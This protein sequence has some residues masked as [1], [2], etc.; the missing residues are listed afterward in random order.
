MTTYRMAM[1]AGNGGQNLWPL[2]FSLGVAA[3]TYDPLSRTNLSDY[4]PG[5]PIELWAELAPTQKASLRRVAYEMKKSDV[6]FVKQGPK[7]VGRGVVKGPY[8][9]DHSYRIIDEYGTPWPH[10][11]PV[12]WDNDF[13]E[14]DILLGG[15]QL[16]VK[17]L[18]Q[19][20]VQKIGF[21]E[22]EKNDYLGQIEAKEGEAYTSEANFRVRNKALINIKKMSSQCSCEV[23]GF[24]FGKYYGDVG[25][26]Y[27]IAHHLRPVS[28][29]PTITTLDD[30]AL[31]CANCHAIIHSKSPQF[32]M[33]D[34][35]LIIA[36]RK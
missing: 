2:C 35:K 21:K 15:E 7:I 31:V 9:F 22:K 11:V 23:C 10:Q 28:S 8:E 17:E 12:F 3:I 24:N 18:S 34:L 4:L 26:G 33:S 13:V 5:E 16:T 32:S 36:A 27:I 6:I 1:R 20:D 29:G 19:D 14:I 30:I 25:H